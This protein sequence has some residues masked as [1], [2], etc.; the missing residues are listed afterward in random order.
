MI[1]VAVTLVALNIGACV[2]GASRD[3]DPYEGPIAAVYRITLYALPVAAAAWA[4]S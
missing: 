3:A 1:Y 4:L 2:V